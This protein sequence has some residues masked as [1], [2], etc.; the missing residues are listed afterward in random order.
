[1]HSRITGL[2]ITGAAA[3]LIAVAASAQNSAFLRDSPIASMDETDRKILRSTI[4]SLVTA[5]DGTETSW[6]NP[7]TGSKGKLQVTNTHADMGTTCRNIKF[8]NESKGR[9]GGGEYRLC[10]AK[11]DTWKFAPPQSG[12]NSS[13]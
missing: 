3:L 5:P 2:I 6:F 11:D 8:Y 13:K 12:D 1:M 9:R 4:E 10:L 7:E